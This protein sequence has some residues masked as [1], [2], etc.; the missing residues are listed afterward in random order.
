MT[1][2]YVQV[3]IVSDFPEDKNNK[4]TTAANSTNNPGMKSFKDR[5]TNNTL[6]FFKLNIE[7]EID[8]I[9]VL[10][11]VFFAFKPYL[12]GGF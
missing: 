11:N 2:S 3:A 1:T 10:D 12:S 9:A 8:N 4:T 5:F 6:K 7:P